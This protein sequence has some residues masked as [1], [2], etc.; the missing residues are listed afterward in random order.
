M[1]AAVGSRLPRALRPRGVGKTT[2]A[3][4]FAKAINRL[5]PTGLEACNECESCSSFNEG[6]SL[7]IHELDAASNNSVEDI[8][9]LDR[10]GAHHPA[11]RAL[12]GIHHRRGGHAQA[13]LN[14]FLKRR[15]RCRPHTRSSSSR[16]PK[17]TRSS[18]PSS[19][20]CQIYDFNRI[21]VEDG[22]RIPQI[23]RL[24]GRHRGRRRVAQPHRPESRRG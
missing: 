4:I 2:C 15:A 11:G 19:L 12:L 20:R 22:G 9:T 6:R 16:R 21:Q 14:A 1:S 7:N 17:N 23:H 24:A 10:T 13:V 3:R 8:R 5:N 18:R